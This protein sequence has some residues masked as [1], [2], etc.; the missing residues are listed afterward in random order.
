[1]VRMRRGVLGIVVA[2]VICLAWAG[3]VWGR[4]DG[5][6]PRA[7]SLV[8]SVASQVDVPGRVVGE[9]AL[10]KIDGRGDLRESASAVG[11]MLV[12]ASAETNGPDQSNAGG[13]IRLAV[14]TLSDQLLEIWQRMSAPEV[15]AERDV[16]DPG[17]LKELPL[18]GDTARVRATYEMIDLDQLRERVAGRNEERAT[19]VGVSGELEFRDVASV[20]IGYALR[21]GSGEEA[22]R[23]VG[24]ADA[25]VAYRVGERATVEAD[26]EW[27]VGARSEHAAGLNV[28]YMLAPDAS[29]T[30][31]YHLL[32]FDD[33]TG[34]TSHHSAAAGVKLRF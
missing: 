21:P 16:T 3:L 34:G 19:Y 20:K 13:S 28:S 27:G 8:P 15:E 31:G 26:V 25:Q 4:A 9:T 14:E 1:M 32:S 30:A 2:S 24:V 33:A 7:D 18:W 5:G 11:E 10:G 12:D 6:A 22:D 17:L 29:L 23:L